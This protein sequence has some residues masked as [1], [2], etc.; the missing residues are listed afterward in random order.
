MS[1]DDEAVGQLIRKYDANQGTLGRLQQSHSEFI[2]QIEKLLA[3]ITA[4]GISVDVTDT[5]FQAGFGQGQIPRN[6][7]NSS[8][9]AY[10]HYALR[11]MRKDDWKT[12]CNGLVSNVSFSNHRI[13]TRTL[14]GALG[15][16]CAGSPYW[17][18]LD[19]PL[20]R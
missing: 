14:P 6:I 15:R 10:W 16:I 9:T 19:T 2:E 20:P 12:V 3:M 18:W 17:T 13:R 11:P 4:Q 1:F 7:L 5:N 8:L